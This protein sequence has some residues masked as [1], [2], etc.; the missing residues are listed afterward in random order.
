MP[1]RALVVDDDP[2]VREMI[3]LMLTLE[4]YEVMTAADGRQGLQAAAASRPE[5]IV[6]DVMMPGLGGP[7]VAARL[8]EDDELAGIPIVFCTAIPDA[9][10]TLACCL[11]SRDTCVSKPFTTEELVG[12][13]TAVVGT[14]HAEE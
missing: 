1:V 4:G 13:V 5:V 3:E 2:S 8:R 9:G 10:E 6:L 14:A 7:Q 11:T 12:A